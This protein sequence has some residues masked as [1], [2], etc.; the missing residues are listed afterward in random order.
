MK[1]RKFLYYY[2]HFTE[3][4]LRR[5]KKSVI[6]TVEK[7]KSELIKQKNAMQ[8]RNTHSQQKLTTPKV[9]TTTL[10]RFLSSFLLSCNIFPSIVRRNE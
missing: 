8:E 4:L 7:R 3:N 2:R 10:I 5:M 6:D 1:S 9:G